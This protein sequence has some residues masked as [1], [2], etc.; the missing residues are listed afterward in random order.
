MLEAALNVAAEPVL[1]WTAYG[2]LLAR[3]GNRGP[4]AAPQGVYACRG[5]QRWLAL[6]VE[7]DAQWDALRTVLGRPAWADDAAL[8]DHP[9]RRAHQDLLDTHL[10]A[11]AA[12]V[13]LTDAVDALVAAGVPAAPAWDP[14]RAREHPQFVDRGFFELV[15]HPV[16]GPQPTPTAPFRLRGV[17]RWVRTPA[18]TLGEH[19]TEVLAGMLGCTEAE[20]AGLRDAGVIGTWPKGL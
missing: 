9:G 17:P 12:D 10:D 5:T 6:A 3:E 13:E 20:L 14:R 18:P 16:C 2:Q 19:N 4:L 11:W 8:A 7:T 1:E 15:D